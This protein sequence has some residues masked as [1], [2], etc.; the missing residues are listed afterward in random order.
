[1]NIEKIK[2]N[3]ANLDDIELEDIAKYEAMT[4][5]PEVIP[6]LIEEIKKRGLN[7]NLY[8]ALAAQ[9]KVLTHEE[10]KVFTDKIKGL[11]CP[12]C[13]RK[14][15]GLVGANIRKSRSYIFISQNDESV[16]IACSSCIKAEKKE[17]LIINCLL[18]WWGSG[19]IYPTPHA[20]IMHF[21]ENGKK[22]TI[23]ENI[24]VK[25]VNNFR[26]KIA[27]IWNDENQIVKFIQYQNNIPN[28]ILNYK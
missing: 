11:P 9:V 16:M 25:F 10:I 2:N 28:N 6:I 22:E 5:E 4:L 24:L 21:I 7:E 15:S 3:Y 27:T 18:G 8:K 13:G 20:I 26:G 1:M 23:S 12:K 14:N 17:Q 19:L